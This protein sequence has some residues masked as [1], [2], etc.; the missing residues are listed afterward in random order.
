MGRII[1][2]KIEYNLIDRCPRR[3]GFDAR[4][5]VIFSKINTHDEAI[6]DFEGIK[7]MSKNFSQGYVAQKYLSKTKITE[8]NKN[9]F[10]EKLLKLVTRE[11]EE[12]FNV[13]IL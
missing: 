11:Y 1:M 5:K 8:I 10:I 4:A 13:T 6:I 7:F 12:H 3:L 9:E 2:T